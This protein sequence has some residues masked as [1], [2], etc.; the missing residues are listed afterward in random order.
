MSDCLLTVG[1]LIKECCNLWPGEQ[2]SDQLTLDTVVLKEIIII[3]A[4][5]GV[6]GDELEK[7]TEWFMVSILNLQQGRG[8]W[9][10]NE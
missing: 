8:P 7:L 6:N 10:I 1:F 4:G 9:K 5:K 2:R 3:E